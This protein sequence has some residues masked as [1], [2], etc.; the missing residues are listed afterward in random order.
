MKTNQF[1]QNIITFALVFSEI[2]WANS[3]EKS[4]K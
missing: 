4:P 1:S 3:R 2:S